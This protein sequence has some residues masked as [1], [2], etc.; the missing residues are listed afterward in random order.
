MYRI[1]I[2]IVER[3]RTDIFYTCIFN[4]IMEVTFIFCP[5]VLVPPR[6]WWVVESDEEG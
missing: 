2:N 4:N 3:P 1:F 6:N 5:R